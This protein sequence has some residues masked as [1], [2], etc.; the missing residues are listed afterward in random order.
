MAQSAGHQQS[1]EFKAGSKCDLFD[2]DNMEWK[3][4]EIVSTFTDEK[5]KW[6]KV[7]CGQKVRDVLAIDPDLRIRTVVTKEEVQKLESA[8]AQIPNINPVVNRILPGTAGQGIY[9][10]AERESLVQFVYI[11]FE[12]RGLISK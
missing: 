12:Q 11:W 9:V 8:A 3:R 4:G 5:G 2:R 10:F 6:M 1:A 7:R